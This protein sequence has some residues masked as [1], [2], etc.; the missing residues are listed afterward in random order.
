MS[1]FKTDLIAF[2]K[3]QLYNKYGAENHDALRYGPYQPKSAG[4]IAE[5]IRNTKKAIGYKGNIIATMQVERLA[6][7]LEKLDRFY[8]LLNHTG[9]TRLIEIIA[10]RL[11][12]KDRV[13][14]FTNNPEYHK[15]FDVARSLKKGTETMDPHFLDFKLNRFDLRPAGYDVE[16]FF[17]EMGVA[18]DFLVEQYAYKENG[19]ALVQVKSG[20]VVLD[21]GGCYGDTALY[22]ATKAG[23]EGKVFTFEFIPN[24]VHILRKNLSLNPELEKRVTVV[25]HPVSDKSDL[26]V[27]YQ[28]FGPASHISGEPFDAQT[29]ETTTLSIDDFVDRYKV[30]KVDFIKMDIEGSEPG[31]LKGA[32]KTIRKFRPVLAVAIY[33]S[34]DDLGDIPAW[35]A[36]LNL[37][38]E[39]Y[40]G[41][42][43]IHAE[44]TILFVKPK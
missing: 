36:S 34:M 22:F 19:K 10:Y 33:H 20:D 12:G 24:N 14:L 6:P 11:L 4:A 31:A 32:E 16:L 3:K 42:Y 40:L 13:K 28:D 41:H 2:V 25:E 8:A 21:L 39:Y 44:E 23:S 26:K 9:K 27:Y 7:Y 38:C 17:G 37:P 30:E 43:T 5:I 35:I 1:N 29:G 18:I 15:A